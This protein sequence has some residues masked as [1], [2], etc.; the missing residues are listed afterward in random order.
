[1]TNTK[2]LPEELISLLERHLKQIEVP[3]TEMYKVRIRRTIAKLKSG[4][5]Q[6]KERELIIDLQSIGFQDIARQVRRGMYV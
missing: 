1:M 3:A 2:L 6:D 5:Y 4:E